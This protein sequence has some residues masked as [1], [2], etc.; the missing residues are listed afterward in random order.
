MLIP[1]ALTGRNLLQTAET[2]RQI[3]SFL[4]KFVRMIEINSILKHDD[5]E[6]FFLQGPF[7]VKIF[8]APA[9]TGVGLLLQN[10]QLSGLYPR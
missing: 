1:Y 7:R 3:Y 5:K 10:L 2:N 9:G 6:P 4:K 8:A